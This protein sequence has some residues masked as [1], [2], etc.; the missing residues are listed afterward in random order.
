MVKAT[1]AE[2]NPIGVRIRNVPAV[3]EAVTVGGMRNVLSAMDVHGV[4]RVFFTDSI[5]S[6]GA[7]FS[8]TS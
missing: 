3:A 8:S 7:A 6:F 5:G 4:R 2:V 1:I